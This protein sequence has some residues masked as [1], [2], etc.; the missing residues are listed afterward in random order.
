MESDRPYRNALSKGEILA[1]INKHSGTQFDP[2]VVKAFLKE[3]NTNGL[4][5]F[6]VSPEEELAFEPVF[7]NVELVQNL[8]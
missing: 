7:A 3:Y 5:P 4:V 6:N 2:Q 8:N 1:E